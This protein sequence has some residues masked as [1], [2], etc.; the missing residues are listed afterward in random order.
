MHPLALGSARFAYSHPRPLLACVKPPTGAASKPPC[1]FQVSTYVEFIWY[2]VPGKY[3]THVHTT[4][5]FFATYW[6]R[7]IVTFHFVCSSLL[8]LRFVFGCVIEWRFHYEVFS[9]YVAPEII[10]GVH[11]YNVHDQALHVRAREH[12]YA[13]RH[14]TTAKSRPTSWPTL[15]P[16]YGRENDC[17]NSPFNCDEGPGNSTWSVLTHAELATRNQGWYDQ[18]S[19]S[20]PA[21]IHNRYMHTYHVKEPHQPEHVWIK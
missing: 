6:G 5:Q 9:S 17:K 14:S 4:T 18:P 13:R 10:R 19:V 3:Y 2:L 21:I 1:A 20:E 11:S 16:L 15:E 7:V 8:S 12:E